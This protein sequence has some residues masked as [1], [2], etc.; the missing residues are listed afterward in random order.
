MPGLLDTPEQ[1]GLLGNDYVQAGGAGAGLGGAFGFLAGGAKG[2]AAGGLAGGL[3]GLLV[4]IAQRIF[5]NN[6][7]AAGALAQGL[8]MLAQANP[9]GLPGLIGGL[10]ELSGVAKPDLEALKNFKEPD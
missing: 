9:V 6:P 8:A 2:A 4:P 7:G 1:G 5:K 10:L 3:G